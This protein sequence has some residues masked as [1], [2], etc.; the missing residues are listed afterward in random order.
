MSSSQA[1]PSTEH[2]T[3]YRADIDGLRALAIGLVVLY[4]AFP[5][6]LPG[7]FIGVDIF[8]VISGY[9][10]S[11][12][13]YEHLSTHRFSFVDFYVRRIKRIFPALLI[14]LIS[15]FALGWFTLLANEYQQLG[16]HIFGGAAF[17]SNLILW[18][19]SGYFDQASHLKPLLHLWSL[20]VEEQFY[21][22]WPLLMYIAWKRQL[23][24]L[25]VACS[26]FII[27]FALNLYQ[28]YHVENIA[29]TFYL[30]HT[31]FWELMAGAILAYLAHDNPN[32]YSKS[33]EHAKNSEHLTHSEHTENSQNLYRSDFQSIVAIALIG[34]GVVL[35]NEHTLF[36]GYWAM[37]PVLGT[38]L[39]IHA[40]PTAWINRTFFSHRYAV[41]LGLISFPL[42]LWHWP[43][44][45]FTRI[46]EGSLITYTGVINRIIAILIAIA[47]AWL[48][49][50]LLER[51]IRFGPYPKTKAVLLTLLM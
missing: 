38:V 47:L 51:P 1:N 34:I 40:G 18:N 45:V 27:S 22:L 35:I 12:I 24:L 43:A 42:Y 20:G 50:W 23:N 6:L 39:L 46:L 25:W 41:W 44:L 13:I 3:K 31:R 28:I 49:Y 16:K 9:L 17:V 37:L 15:C 10:I 11:S 2:S 4:H 48:T 21:F 29:T 30:P 26:I 5:K 14:V 8:F 33:A 36:P 32:Q 7:G 19:E